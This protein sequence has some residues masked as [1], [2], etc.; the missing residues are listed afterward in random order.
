MAHLLI[1][2]PP[3][4]VIF[5][6]SRF[7]DGDE[8]YI[9][10]HLLYYCSFLDDVPAINVVVD[11]ENVVVTRGHK[12]LE[13]AQLLNRRTILALVDNAS[14]KFAVEALLSRTHVVMLDWSK[15]LVGAQRDKLPLVWHVYFFERSLQP[16]EQLRFASEVAGFFDELSQQ[17]GQTGEAK[18]L[19]GDVNFDNEI[20]A[21]VFQVYAPIGDERWYGDYLLRAR[22]FSDECVR[23]LSFQG[24]KFMF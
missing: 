16:G 23:I 8:S 20:N 3:T 19:V 2:L 21:A 22:R 14:P 15:T 11:H 10:E 9:F 24:R 1:R 13:S 17:Y 12:Y 4:Y 18:W 6:L 7:P 5:D